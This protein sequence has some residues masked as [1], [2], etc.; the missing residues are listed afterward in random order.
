MVVQIRVNAQKVIRA[1]PRTLYG[2]NVEWID[3]GN[4]IF[5]PRSGKFDQ[6]GDPACARG[7]GLADSLSGGLFSDHFHWK[8]SIGPR[9]RRPMKEHFPKVPPRNSRWGRM[10]RSTWLSR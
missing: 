8:E 1:I 4:G 10:K 6:S 2:T 5:E 3:N 9:D 7:G